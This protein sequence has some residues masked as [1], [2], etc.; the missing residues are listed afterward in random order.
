MIA[1]MI[2]IVYTLL[3]GCNQFFR[4]VIVIQLNYT[5][6]YIGDSLQAL[7]GSQITRPATHQC[8][9]TVFSGSLGC[10]TGKTHF[11]Y[12]MIYAF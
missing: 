11:V 12:E 1:L 10:T 2:I 3:Q 9:A 6:S 8:D 7:P 4:T 5:T